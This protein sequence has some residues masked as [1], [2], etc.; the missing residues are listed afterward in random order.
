MMPE[1]ERHEANQQRSF[2][3]I[4]SPLKATRKQ[5][6]FRRGQQLVQTAYVVTCKFGLQVLHHEAWRRGISVT[7]VPLLR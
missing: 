1:L 3:F 7:P 5:I 6:A 2:F 4:F